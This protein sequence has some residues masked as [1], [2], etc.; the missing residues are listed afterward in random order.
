MGDVH[1][2]PVADGWKVVRGGTTLGTFEAEPEAIAAGYHLAVTE[3]LELV[4][5]VKV[6]RAAPPDLP[7]GGADGRGSWTQVS[8]ARSS[9]AAA[10]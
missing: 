10:G 8:A 9:V 7:G 6:E 4:I 3:N 1:V 5:H 2:V